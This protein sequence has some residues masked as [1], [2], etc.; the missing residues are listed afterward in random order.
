MDDTTRGQVIGSAAREKDLAD[1]YKD[2]AWFVAF[3]P[4]NN[5]KIAVSVLVEHGGHGGS[6]AAPIAKNVIETYFNP[7][8]PEAEEG[9]Q[10]GT[11]MKDQSVVEEI[12]DDQGNAGN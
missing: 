6:A 7:P 5:P 11:E 4:Q 9:K 1:Q 2:H 12:E 10:Q 8:K 3:A